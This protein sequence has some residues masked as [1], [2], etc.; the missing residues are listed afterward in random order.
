MTSYFFRQLY[1]YDFKKY[2]LKK[3]LYIRILRYK[4]KG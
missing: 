1:L 2:P 3:N 4:P